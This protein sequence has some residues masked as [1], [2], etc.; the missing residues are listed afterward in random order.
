M[1][2]I[3]LQSKNGEILA[4]SRDISEKFGKNHNHVLR[5]IDNLISGCPNLDS[6]MFYETTYK[7]R[8][9][10][11]RCFDINRDGFS[12][13]AMGFTGKKALEWKLKYINAFNVM[14][15]KLK[16]GSYLSEEEKLKLQLFS[17]D[18]LEVVNAHN[19]LVELATAPLIAD[20]ERM[21][22]KEEFHDAIAVA[23]NCIN[24]GEFAGT[25]QNNSNI[26]FGRN[27]IMDWC[28]DEGYL[29]SSYNLKNK[30]SQQMLDSGYMKYKENINERNGK[31]Y[32]TYT[33]LLSGKG[34][35]WLTKKLL[36]YFKE[37]A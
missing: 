8:G 25:F 32:I 11:Y 20:N 7:N 36:E 24:F 33:P 10:E 12:L 14:E 4:S 13:L 28:R 15:E 35:I 19:K 34:Q 6:E 27:K 31:K 16:A 30:P 2:E 21:K 22:P 23:E 29:C 1:N 37:V 5:D 26:S 18:S 3:V 9:K 17:K